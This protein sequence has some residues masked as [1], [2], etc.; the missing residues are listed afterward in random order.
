MIRFQVT[1]TMPLL[2]TVLAYGG[3][4]ESRPVHAAE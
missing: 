1:F 4:L 2:G 3:V